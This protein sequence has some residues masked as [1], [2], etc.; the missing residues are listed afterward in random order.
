MPLKTNKG[1]TYNMDFA[2]RWDEIAAALIAYAEQHQP[3]T[4][5]QLFYA[6]VVMGLVEKTDANAKKVGEMVAKLRRRDELPWEH[7]ADGSRELIEPL[8][9]PSIRSG[10]EIYLDAMRID[11]WRD[12]DET[13]LVVVEKDALAGVIAPITD[14]YGVALFPA[15]GYSSVTWLK[16]IAERI[17]ADGRP[18]VIYQLG[19]FDPSGLDASR[20]ARKDIEEFAQSFAGITFERIAITSAQIAE[21][22]LDRLSLAGRP[23]KTSDP[24]TAA[25]FAAYGE[26]AVSIELDAIPPAELREIVRTALLNHISDTEIEAADA[27]ARREALAIRK[28][29]GGAKV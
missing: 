13:V 9:Y 3:V 8:T 20:A 11:P 25:F 16:T 12:K 6:A 17:D 5:R 26:G 21:M 19:D 28:K 4:S 27:K 23:T 24:R 7:I 22:D 14:H 29:L 2:R 18:A 15:R 1:L 10:I